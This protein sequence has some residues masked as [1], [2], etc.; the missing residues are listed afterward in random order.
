MTHCGR[1]RHDGSSP[2]RDPVRLLLFHLG[3]VG[4][5]DGRLG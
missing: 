5:P 2:Q 3:R 1:S 4:K